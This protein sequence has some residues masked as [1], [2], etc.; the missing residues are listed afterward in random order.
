MKDYYKILGVE[1]TATPEEI[2]K[3]YKRLA[4][5]YHPD[6]NKDADA[7][8][9]FKE[10]AEAYETLGDA[11]KREQYDKPAVNS[12][13]FNNFNNSNFN[14]NADD[15]ADVFGFRRQPKKPRY[16]ARISLEDAYRGTVIDF[17]NGQVKINEGAYTGQIIHTMSCEIEVLILPHKMYKLIDNN[18]LI[19]AVINT[20]EALL[21]ATLTL[22]HIDGKTYNIKVP[23]EVQEGQIIKMSGKGMPF[24]HQFTTQGDLLIQFHIVTS[25]L[26]ESEKEVII[27]LNKVRTSINIG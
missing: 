9:K 4:S 22:K 11:K 1:K 27:G 7:E 3:A 14:F 2:K 6:K 19:I 20:F 18:L 15:F 16:L 12:F 24:S 13:N 25:S 26:T 17:Q 21:G 5:K 23:A 10:V 8:S